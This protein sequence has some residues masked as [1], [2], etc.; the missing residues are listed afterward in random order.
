MD[1]LNYN[2]QFK[3]ILNQEE[4]SRIQ[5]LQLRESRMKYWRLRHEAY[6]DERNISDSD[7]GRVWLN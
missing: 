6:I 4:I 7:S 3:E 2:D 5:S 1:S